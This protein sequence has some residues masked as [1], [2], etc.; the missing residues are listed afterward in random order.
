MEVRKLKQNEKFDARLIS[1]LAFHQRMEDPEKQRQESEADPVEDWG[2]FDENGRLMAHIIRHHFEFR[3]DGQWVPGGGIGAVS[4]LP[5]YRNSGA[6]RAIFG[7]LLPEA[8]RE[9]EV[10]SA[11]YP[12]SHAFYRKFGYE[13]VRLKDTYRFPLSVLREYRFA[14]QAVQWQ[15][16]SS[17]EPYLALYERFASCYNLAIRRDEKRMLENHLRGDWKKDREFAYLLK[18]DGRPVAYLIFLDIRHDPAAILS[19]QDAA[20]DGREGFLALLGFLA[21]FSADYGSIEMSLPVSLQLTS[22]IHAPDAY[23]ISQSAEWGY[24]VRAVNAEKLLTLIQKP[25]GCAFTVRVSDPLI[26]EN[27]ATWAV[28]SGSVTH[29]DAEADL[30]VSVQVLGQLACGCVSLSEAALHE[31]VE[32]SGNEA[33]LEQVFVRKPLWVADHY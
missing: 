8:Y 19:V 11:L 15:E 30:S 9:G 13:T 6:V 1:T 24:M 7:K 23:E 25:V 3:L 33:V 28:R 27:N 16:N 20:W 17:V 2:A 21:R 4:T 22:L 14:G 5:E 26:P 12:F 29:T 32:I 18:N 10:L 31:D